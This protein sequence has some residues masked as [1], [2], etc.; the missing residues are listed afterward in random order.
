MTELQRILGQIE[1]TPDCEVIP[2]R[3]QPI[4]REG[5][6]LPDDLAEFYRRCGGVSL[7]GHSTYPVRIVGPH[8]L[9]RSNP[10][11][12]GTECPD[13][14]SDA[15]YIVARGG[16]EEAI[17]LNCSSE[18]L[19]QCYDSV[20]DSHGVAGSC[21]VVAQSFT[22]LIQRLLDS[23]GGYWYW[24]AGGAPDYGDAYDGIER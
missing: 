18:R 3:G 20:W 16:S 15:W 2:P 21:R 6:L 1:R 14:I 19:G 4:L 23:Q 5:D 10:E 12:A 11:I 24:L 8:E 17:S 9:V 7:F 22:E 13:D